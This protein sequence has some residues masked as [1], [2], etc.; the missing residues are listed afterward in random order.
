MAESIAHRCVKLGIAEE[1]R[2]LCYDVHTEFLTPEGGFFDVYAIR[3]NETI[4]VEIFNTHLPNSLPKPLRDALK[5]CKK[6]KNIPDFIVNMSG[7]SSD[8]EYTPPPY[9]IQRDRNNQKTLSE[10]PIESQTQ[11]QRGLSELDFD[12]MEVLQLKTFK[13]TFKYLFLYSS[14]GLKRKSRKE[15]SDSDLM[16]ELVESRIFDEN[17]LGHI[18]L[19]L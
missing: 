18:F 14:P 7:K 6:N 5:D 10:G 2:G 12:P 17:R 16:R 3:G 15:V 11:Q 8:L 1:L 4:Y 13:E 9:R 19:W